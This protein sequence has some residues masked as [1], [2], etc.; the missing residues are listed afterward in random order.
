MSRPSWREAAAITLG[1]TGT[2][3]FLY[4]RRS[5]GAQVAQL[6]EQR[7]ENP[8]VGGSIPP[9]GTT[10]SINNMRI[11]PHQ[12]APACGLF[13][14]HRV[15]TG[16]KDFYRFQTVPGDSMRHGC[17]IKQELGTSDRGSERRSDAILHV[18]RSVTQNRA[19]TAWRSWSV[20]DI[21]PVA[22]LGL[23]AEHRDRTRLPRR[24]PLCGCAHAEVPSSAT[25]FLATKRDPAQ[26]E[27]RR[28]GR[29]RHETECRGSGHGSRAEAGR[30]TH[31]APISI[32]GHSRPAS[33]DAVA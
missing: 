14:S 33:R 29:G 12:T 8:C 15:A 28:S 24:L 21:K 7:T 26:P 13:M 9:L 3:N 25:P 17:D 4:K 18:A 19:R 23:A 31:Q 32:L 2:R 27:D 22:R 5:L 16:I 10:K 6:V 30:P 11:L 1:W 20:H